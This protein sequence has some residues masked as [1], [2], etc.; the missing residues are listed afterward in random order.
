V[1]DV[2]DAGSDGG[3]IDELIL[4]VTDDAIDVPN[5]TTDSRINSQL[6]SPAPANQS[7]TPTPI[8]TTTTTTTTPTTTSTTTVLQQPPSVGI[9]MMTTKINT[10]NRA[11]T[12]MTAMVEDEGENLVFNWLIEKNVKLQLI[13]LIFS[14]LATV[15]LYW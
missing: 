4:C 5:A 12:D 10:S 15:V 3:A 2:S 9:T 13:S 11:M 8:T 6:S 7:P 14:A 1:I